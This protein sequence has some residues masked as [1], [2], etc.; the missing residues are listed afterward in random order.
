MAIQRTAGNAAAARLLGSIQ[1][2]RAVIRT[3]RA[4]GE[5]TVQRNGIWIGS[6]RMPQRDRSDLARRTGQA[7]IATWHVPPPPRRSRVGLAPQRRL[8][9]RSR[10]ARPT[11]LPPTTDKR[12]QITEV[13][14]WIARGAYGQVY[15]TDVPNLIV[16]RGGGVPAE[17]ARHLERVPAHENVLK[18]FRTMESES[19]SIGSGA[20]YKY[21]RGG[22]LGPAQSRLK[23]DYMT[24]AIG[25]HEF[26]GAIQLLGLDI[27]RGVAHLH[28]HGVWHGDLKS[29]NVMLGHIRSRAHL[30]DIAAFGSDEGSV[31]GNAFLGWSPELYDY[32]GNRFLVESRGQFGERVF[33]RAPQGVLNP[34][35]ALSEFMVHSEEGGPHPAFALDVNA[36]GRLACE[37]L[38]CLGHRDRVKLGPYWEAASDFAR[39]ITLD[40]GQRPTAEEALQMRF[41]TDLV[42]ERHYA[43]A[44]INRDRDKITQFREAT[45]T[46][47]SA[48]LDE[49]FEAARR[50]QD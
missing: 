37:P 6:G 26:F 16:K 35:D 28:R 19:G 33:A 10:P 46:G 17:S 9:P 7:P 41:M 31:A 23:Q 38:G 50:R 13:K 48:E 40:P 49:R 4:A 34:G 22:E 21:V 8:Q 43:S 27:M 12:G 14:E 18:A 47:D 25:P 30:I 44:L 5:A 20:I 11:R 29:N 45:A 39:M 2:D 15:A 36:A 3:A 1:D 32:L 42:L 24:D